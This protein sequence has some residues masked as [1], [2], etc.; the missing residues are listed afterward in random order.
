M[1]I[2][3][4][5]YGITGYRYRL[6]GRFAEKMKDGWPIIRSVDRPCESSINCAQL[7]CSR[8]RIILCV[9]IFSIFW[10][11]VSEVYLIIYAILLIFVGIHSLP[12]LEAPVVL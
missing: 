9:D 11:H 1:D 8:L 2:H 4:L 7:I 6:A 5:S 12:N 10:F 3:C